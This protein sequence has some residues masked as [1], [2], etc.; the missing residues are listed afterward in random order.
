MIKVYNNSTEQ[1]NAALLSA[2]NANIAIE[3]EIIKANTQN[4]TAINAIKAEIITNNSNIYNN[5]KRETREKFEEAA[6][7]AT[8]AVVGGESKFISYIGQENGILIAASTKL[9]TFSV[10]TITKVISTTRNDPTDLGEEADISKD[11]LFYIMPLFKGIVT[12]TFLQDN[13]MVNKMSYFITDTNNIISGCTNDYRGAYIEAIA[14]PEYANIPVTFKIM[15]TK[16]WR[17]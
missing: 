14:E 1:I 7:R 8:K 4:T 17:K 15:Q 13:N 10:K 2:N 9:P 16:L 11:S 12:L 6:K 5:A 3:N